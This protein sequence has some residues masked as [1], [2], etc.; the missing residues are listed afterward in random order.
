MTVR[1]GL[2]GC[3]AVARRFH[4]PGLRQSGIVDVVAFAGGSPTSAEAAAA[5]WGSGVVC[6]EWREVLAR[7]DVD[8]VDI[9][10][11]NGLHAEIAIAAAEAGKHVLVEKPIARTLAEADAMIAAA[12]AAG[13]MMMTAH[14][15]R[16]APVFL[17]MRAA[18]EQG[19]LGELRGFRSAFGH[20]GPETWAPG[21][22]WF[23]DPEAAGG[24]VLLDLGIHVA[25]LLRAVLGEEIVEV[26]AMLAP[27]EVER[28]AQAVLRTSS[29][30][31]GSMHVSWDAVSGLDHQLTIFGTTGTAHMDSFTQ[32]WL[33]PTGSTEVEPLRLPQDASNP[34][35]EFARA[36]ESGNPPPV[37][38]DDGRAALAIID[39]AYRA[40]AT[41][42]TQK[43]RRPA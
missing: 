27:G 1:I 11:P 25:D 41:A 21:A 18:I 34:Y 39:A 30:A 10:T 26:A 32:P 3:G 35:A 40:A 15:V 22:T 8:A 42:T 31:L 20:A 43:V 16:F 28:T 9:C 29:G 5:E 36:I 12:R 2:I 33:R 4:L 7:A 24:G 19:R 6:G 17:A 37:T 38:G 23:T 13:V 14:N